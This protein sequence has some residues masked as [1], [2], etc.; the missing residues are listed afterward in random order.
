[1]VG[2]VED[3]FIYPQNGETASKDYVDE[4]FLA[5]A[6]FTATGK[7]FDNDCL[8]RVN[9]DLVVKDKGQGNVW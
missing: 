3:V 1:M 5:K 8:I 9:G 4:N 7:N 6:V 2:E